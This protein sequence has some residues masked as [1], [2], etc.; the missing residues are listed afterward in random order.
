MTQQG[1]KRH[2]PEQI[3]RKLRAACALRTRTT[4]VRKANRKDERTRARHGRATEGPFGVVVPVAR[5]LH[6]QTRGDAQPVVLG[7]VQQLP[8]DPVRP[9]VP[10]VQL[11]LAPAPQRVG[12]E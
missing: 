4:C 10:L 5:V 9:G 12:A 11:P 6:P 7:V 1:K 2:R 8:L 3:V